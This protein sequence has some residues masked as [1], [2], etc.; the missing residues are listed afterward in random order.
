MHSWFAGFYPYDSPQYVIVVFSEEGTGGGSHLRTCL[1]NNR[2]RPVGR[3]SGHE[4]PGK[5]WGVPVDNKR[6]GDYNIKVFAELQSCKAYILPTGFPEGKGFDGKRTVFRSQKRGSCLRALKGSCGFVREAA[7][8]EL[9]AKSAA[10]FPRYRKKRGVAA[11]QF[12]WYHGLSRPIVGGEGLFF[13]L[14]LFRAERRFQSQ[15]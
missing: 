12:G 4:K 6:K 11:A 5:T 10:R 15:K 13:R 1:S 9:C 14:W 3:T 8:P 2:K 7:V